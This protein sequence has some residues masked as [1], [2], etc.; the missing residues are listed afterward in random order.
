[1]N[2]T[3]QMVFNFILP[4]FGSFSERS[5]KTT[6]RSDDSAFCLEVKHFALRTNG[7]MEEEPHVERSRLHRFPRGARKLQPL[8]ET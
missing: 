7:Q 1:M 5:W 4:E 2:A 3:G 8:H 6:K